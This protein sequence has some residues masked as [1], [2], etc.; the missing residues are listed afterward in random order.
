MALIHRNISL[1]A[2]LFLL[3][4]IGSLMLDSYA[5]LNLIDVVVPF[6]GSFKPFWQGLGTVAF[7]LLVALVLTG[8]LR[9]RLGQRTFR[10]VHWFAYAMWPIA[11]AHSIGNGTNGTEKWFLALAA[12]SVV[13]VGGSLVVAPVLE[14]PGNRQSPTKEPVMTPQTSQLP[15]TA[16]TLGPA[17]S[18][19]LF[20]AGSHATLADHERA[21]GP[22]PAHGIG[23]NFINVLEQSGLTGR[24]GAAFASWRKLAATG[25]RRG[26]ALLQAKPVVIANGAEG[27]PLSF[28][29][30]T[31][32][33][34][35]P[36]LVLD[37]LLV[38]ARAVSASSLYI[39]TTAA[40]MPAVEAAIAERHDARRIKVVEAPETFISGQ[41]SAVVNTI[42][43]G[44]AL[45][46]DN[47]RRL[48]ESGLKGRPT[49]VLNVETLAHM[50]LIARY[51]AEWFR[52]AGSERDPGTRLVSVSGW[53]AEQ[54]LEIEGDAGLG[55]VLARAGVDFTGVQAVL[56]G[57]YHGRWVKPLDYRLSP[58]WSGG[59]NGPPR[60]G[61]APCALH[62]AVRAG[63]HRPDR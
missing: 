39:Y 15:V 41:A 62:R 22:L 23:A 12:G 37:G 14:L 61:R 54:V 6:L 7:D 19:R 57:G 8:L 28:K 49:L 42:G 11:L 2:T 33:L 43:G 35:A 40:A 13:A 9:H 51:G 34:H 58:V 10:A 36:H 26:G 29:D 4:H 25:Q 5:K 3:M 47:R 63:G 46:L 38:A 55:S 44:I 16:Q 17:G 27:E 21:Y 1:L 60:R 56:V 50:A 18:N 30:K 52:S 48:S 59:P 32:L 24:G 31:L 53:G 45:P 20:A